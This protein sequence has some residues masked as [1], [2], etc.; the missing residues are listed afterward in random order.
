MKKFAFTFSGSQEFSGIITRHNFLLRCMP[1]TYPF[2][3]S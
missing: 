2:Q 3:R 1:G